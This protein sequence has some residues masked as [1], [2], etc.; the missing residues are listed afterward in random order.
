MISS[1]SADDWRSINYR[2]IEW[3]IIG[4]EEHWLMISILSIEIPDDRGDN[5]DTEQRESIKGL[6]VCFCHVF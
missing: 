5:D 1:P 6:T 2:P 3:N 4:K